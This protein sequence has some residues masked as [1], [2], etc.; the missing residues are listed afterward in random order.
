MKVELRCATIEPGELCATIAGTTLMLEL[1]AG[2]SA[3][4][5]TVSPYTFSEIHCSSDNFLPDT[6]VGFPNARFGAGKGLIILDN[7]ECAGTE[8]NILSCNHSG[9]FQQ[10]CHHFEDASVSCQGTIFPLL[11]I[12]TLVLTI[13]CVSIAHTCMYVT[14]FSL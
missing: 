6:V 2:N 3:L 1:S 9:L 13:L 8:H 11:N 7:V 14:I 12:G 4:V 10:N 5:K